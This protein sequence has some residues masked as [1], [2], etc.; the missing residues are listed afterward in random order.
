MP[1]GVSL[2]PTQQ[3]PQQTLQTTSTYAT[4]QKYFVAKAINHTEAEVHQLQKVPSLQSCRSE[5]A[6]FSWDIVL[7]FSVDGA[8]KVLMNTAPIIWILTC[9]AISKRSSI[10]LKE[11]RAMG[12]KFGKGSNH[13]HD[14]YLV[15]HTHEYSAIYAR[16][17]IVCHKYKPINSCCAELHRTCGCT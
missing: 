6:G 3:M 1:I 8:Q 4:L 13:V 15:S 16:N 7:D 14:P 9:I 2:G 5:D 11:C 17:S 10:G 12:K